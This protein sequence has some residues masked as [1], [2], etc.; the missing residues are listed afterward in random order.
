MYACNL[1]TI[2][3]NTYRTYVAVLYYYNCVIAHTG[4]KAACSPVWIWQSGSL[5]N[6]FVSVNMMF[7][8]LMYAQS[9][10]HFSFTIVYELSNYFVRVISR[11]FHADILLPYTLNFIQIVLIFMRLWSSTS[12]SLTYIVT[13]ICKTIS[14]RM[15]DKVSGSMCF[16]VGFRL[17]NISH[18]AQY[19]F[20]RISSNKISVE[21]LSNVLYAGYGITVC[22][23][24]VYTLFR[25]LDSY[26]ISNWL[27]MY[28]CLDTCFFYCIHNPNS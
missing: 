8:M 25:T 16:R 20:K 9:Y 24:F 27:Y 14:F 13:Y 1:K 2:S 3:S 23:K 17:D 18:V 28:A 26:L 15:C 7:C 4:S 19:G 12:N 10:K 5:G 11:Y 6:T 21:I 22:L